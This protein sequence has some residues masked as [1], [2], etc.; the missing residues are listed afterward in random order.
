L[1]IT[2]TERQNLLPKALLQFP[3]KSHGFLKASEKSLAEASKDLKSPSSLPVDPLSKQV[4]GV[5]ISGSERNRSRSGGKEATV[6]NV[7]PPVQATKPHDSQQSSVTSPNTANVGAIKREV[8]AVG[9]RRHTSEKSVME[10]SRS[11]PAV[12]KSDQSSHSNVSESAPIISTGRALNNNRSHQPVTHQQETITCNHENQN[13]IIAA[14]IRVSET[15][16]WRLT[17]GTL[18]IDVESSKKPG[19]QEA[20]RIVEE[21]HL[22]PLASSSVSPPDSLSN[23]TR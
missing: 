4:K 5:S 1:S 10:N 2:G 15:H 8:G 23:I 22:E 21:S 3:P 16:R 20:R 7:T 14:H 13:V 12:S 11:F 19:Y 17:F 9:V 18:G 6:S